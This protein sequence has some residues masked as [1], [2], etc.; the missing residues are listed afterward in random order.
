MVSGWREQFAAWCGRVIVLGGF[1]SLVSLILRPLRWPRR[2]DDLFSLINLPVGP[3]L[4][5]IALL[6]VV[7]GAVRRRIRFAWWLLLA[8]QTVAAIYLVGVLSAVLVNSGDARESV[9]W[10]RP[11]WSSTPASRFRWWRCCG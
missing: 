2:I 6:F 9:R 1:W 10:M 4:F 11:S 5:S 3:S 7:G 8:F